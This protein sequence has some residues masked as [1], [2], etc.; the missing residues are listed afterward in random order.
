MGLGNQ[1]GAGRE[2]GHTSPC[3]PH[4]AGEDQGCKMQRKN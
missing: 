4:C 2:G 1:A 3:G